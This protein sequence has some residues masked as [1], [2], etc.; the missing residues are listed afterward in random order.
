[1]ATSVPWYG[2]MQMMRHPAFSATVMYGSTTTVA[3]A[4]PFIIALYTGAMPL[5]PRQV[6]IASRGKKPSS[7]SRP[8]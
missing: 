5:G 6:L 7:M 4:S 2:A 1:M 3:S 8:R